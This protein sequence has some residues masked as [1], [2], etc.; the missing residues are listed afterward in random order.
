[1]Q[2][3]DSIAVIPARGGSKRIPRKNVRPFC[4]L[5]MIARSI[6]TAREAGI[7]SHVV[8]ST[9]DPEIADIARDHGALVPFERPAALADDFTT[10]LQ[11]V[12]HAAH[13]LA[14]RGMPSDHL[15]C[16]Y[17]TAP[18]MRASDLID[19]RAML[20]AGVGANICVPVTQYPFPIQRALRLG[21]GGRIAMMDPAQMVARSQDLEP[22]WHDTGQ[23]YFATTERWLSGEPVFGPGCVGLPIESWRVQDIDTPDDWKR[24]ELLFA[25]LNPDLAGQAC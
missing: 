25:Q 6:G 1:V 9:D 11:V 2:S 24:A 13:A 5:P 4:G 12:E 20:S 22:A 15:C 19:A 3:G 16:I 23:F 17:A 21:E 10:T 14:E 7:F 8:V 18:F